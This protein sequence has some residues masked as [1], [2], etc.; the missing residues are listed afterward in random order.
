MVPRRSRL[1]LH[2]S[3]S[4]LQ[5]GVI[6]R[7]WFPPQTP[8]SSVSP[9][10]VRPR[11]SFVRRE[12]PMLSR[13]FDC[14]SQTEVNFHTFLVG[15]RLSVQAVRVL[16]SRGPRVV[17]DVTASVKGSVLPSTSGRDPCQ[18]SRHRQSVG[19][20]CVLRREETLVLSHKSVRDHLHSSVLFPSE[21][22]EFNW[23]RYL[24]LNSR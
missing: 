24:C 11:R 18:P 12:L 6:S 15:L 16:G 14:L 17:T 23:R 8:V 1:K 20:Y 3:L 5:P 2:I 10:E 4:G 19:G 22:T 7:R 21:F 13:H 9:F